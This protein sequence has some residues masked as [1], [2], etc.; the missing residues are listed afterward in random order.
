MKPSRQPQQSMIDPETSRADKWSILV[1]VNGVAVNE[2]ADGNRRVREA[3]LGKLRV[4]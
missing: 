3:R 2:S 4:V 1:H